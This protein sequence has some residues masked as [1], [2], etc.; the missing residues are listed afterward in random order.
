LRALVSHITAEGT[1]AAV[2][3]SFVLASDPTQYALV[4]GNLAENSAT[5]IIGMV[6]DLPAGEWKV[7]IVTQYT[8]GGKF[9][10]EPRAVESAFT[11]TVV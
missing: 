8:D 11:L 5:K 1:D 6:P 2:G 9:L 4:E 3:I 10:K 7:K